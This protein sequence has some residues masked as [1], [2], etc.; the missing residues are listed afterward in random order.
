MEKNVT[1]AETPCVSAKSLSVGGSSD[2]IV[3][4][5]CDAG[6]NFSTGRQ[7][8]TAE[9]AYLGDAIFELLVREKLLRDGVTFR[10]ISR[11]A[12]DFVSATAQAAMYHRVFS[13][14]SE[15]E[16]AIAKRGR[17]LHSTSRAK[18]AAVTDY[19]HATGLEA[20]FGFLHNNGESARLAEVFEL[21]T[22]KF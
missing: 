6:A 21:C 13:A 5:K 10:N 11:R 7:L 20:V 12:R 4:A 16:Q 18:N 1:A 9:L 15:E 19:R 14:L 3:G 17:N 22:A 8:G 2:A